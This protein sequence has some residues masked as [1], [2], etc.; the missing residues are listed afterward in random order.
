MAFEDNR[1]LSKVKGSKSRA[2]FYKNLK[3]FWFHH[4][5]EAIEKIKTSAIK[6]GFSEPKVFT[7]SAEYQKITRMKE[8]SFDD[9]DK[10]KV[11]KNFS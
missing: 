5:S 2:A 7:A 8:I 9:E 1:K 6:Y 11:L 10:L 3:E 4:E